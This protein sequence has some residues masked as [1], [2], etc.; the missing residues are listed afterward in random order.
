[1]GHGRDVRRS[2]RPGGAKDRPAR[3]DDLRLETL[4]EGRCVQA[5]YV[6]P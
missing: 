1:M 5:L 3:L 6:G 2:A 4:S